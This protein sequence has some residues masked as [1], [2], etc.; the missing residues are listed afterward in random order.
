[1]HNCWRPWL[2]GKRKPAPSPGAGTCPKIPLAVLGRRISGL[3]AP[4]RSTWL[5]AGIAAFGWG[6][7]MA[8]SSSHAA[9]NVAE[10]VRGFE[11]APGLALT[12]WATEPQ[13]QNGVAFS[14]DNLGRCYVAET[15]RYKDS[16]FDITQHTNWLLNDLAFHSPAD[17]AGFLNGEFNALQPDL[18]TRHSE[19]VRILEDRQ[20][21]GRADFSDLFA[22]GFN[23]PI[24]GT[25]AGVLARDG[26]VWFA[27]MPSLWRMDPEPTA[28]PARPRT[29]VAHGFGVHIGVT[30][31]DLHGLIKGPDGRIYV[32][33]GDRGLDVTTLTNFAPVSPQLAWTLR[34]T[35]GVLR[36]EPDGTGVEL[37]CLGLR[38]P[39]EL[40]FDD[41]GNLWTVDNDT[42]GADPCR[43]LHLVEGG[44]YGWRCS[45]QHME[46]FGPWVKEELWRGGQDGI[47]PLAGTVSQGP[48]G[49]S[50]Y[51][52]TGFGSRFAGRFVHCDFPAGILSFSVKPDGASYRVDQ[53]E[54]LL[55]N[56]WATD[57]D[58]A[59][60]GGL[61]V[62]D[63]VSGWQ[64]PDKGRIYRIT[65]PQYVKDPQVAEVRALL[66]AGMKARAAD[67]LR[68]LLGHID[69]RVRLE[70]QWELVA[71]GTDE[72]RALIPLALTSPNPLTRRHALWG[73][74]GI[75]RHA[76]TSTGAA[77]LASLLK[78]LTDP[79]P[80]I[81]GQ[82][83]LTILGDGRLVNA[84][85]AAATLLEDPSA[86]VRL[87]ALQ[88]YHRRFR[89]PGYARGTVRMFSESANG[90]GTVEGHLPTTELAR[91]LDAGS[92]DPFI[93]DAAAQLLTLVPAG[94]FTRRFIESPAEE[95]RYAALLS[96]RRQA[97]SGIISFL[98][99]P[100]PRLV[101]EAGRAIHDV[102]IAASFAPLAQMLTRVDCPTNLYS[103]VIDAGLRLGSARHATILGNFA[104]RA[105]VSPM[106]RA[107]AI[108]ALGEWS[109]PGP[110]DRI[111]GLWRPMVAAR[112]GGSEE[113]ESTAE[114]PPNPALATAL[115][116]A[117]VPGPISRFDGPATL[118]P[119]LGRSASYAEGMAVH[120]KDASAKKALL[121]KAGEWVASGDPEVQLAVISTSIRLRAKE[122][123]SPLY[124][125]F[126]SAA[127]TEAVRAAIIPALA[128]LNAVQT[129]DAVR[130]SLAGTNV[131]LRR[132]AI[133]HLDRLGGDDTL[134]V[135]TEL[136]NRALGQ[137]DYG[138]AQ[139]AYLA[140][141]KLGT[142]AADALL[143]SALKK[144][145]ATTFPRELRLDVIAAAEVRSPQSPS[146]AE[147]LRQQRSGPV[148]PDPLARWA[149]ALTGGS[150][151]RGKSIFFNHPA[152]Q[153]LR[154]HQV[155]AAGGTVGPKLDGI[156][157]QRDRSYLLESI[158]LPNRQYAPGFSPPP[159]SLSAM[160]EG[161]G[162]ILTPLELRD[163]VEFLAQLK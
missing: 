42:A 6:Q 7:A 123:S 98:S 59:P 117:T 50:Y 141:A 11:L 53:K 147:E 101:S 93:L 52:G 29:R 109:E 47:L 39:Q 23:T 72:L 65:D 112:N 99:D 94:D 44:D 153:C 61:Y 63:W 150:A 10:H 137:S 96:L 75:L 100:S 25:A 19:A 86:R 12:V 143:L 41:W 78:L 58:F 34:D 20:G 160:P 1:M 73:I 145:S 18:L 83:V 55:W 88:A 158:V 133:A 49:L 15:H 32:S 4:I 163:L 149:N 80:E 51:P 136:L 157:A 22:T 27:N 91:L 43:V 115:K 132:A 135:L 131:V 16:I 140:L 138:T 35:G 3:A 90:N 46:G 81:R 87:L 36:C 106:A 69:R 31:H 92:V 77:E 2:P 118:P 48:S 38:N 128:A 110:L 37:F 119:D 155:L 85:R 126:Q 67:E 89:R 113:K 56:C 121:G 125:L 108:R 70:A 152:A 161:F 139:S 64:M 104:A 8:A 24:D 17:R 62:L 142:P 162:E 122:A 57:V 97:R 66:G 151:I 129:S 30:G 95:T 159:G 5:F 28:G 13:V 82:A 102:P 71:R 124:E 84:E 60:D 26:Q 45:Y 54:R 127:T 130:H 103:R 21:S 33:F 40:A 156:G 144:V 154:C 14:F 116:S 107:L 76:P 68:G 79:D 114:P 146:L 111:N 120:R 148:S 105:D 9:T 134:N 74:S